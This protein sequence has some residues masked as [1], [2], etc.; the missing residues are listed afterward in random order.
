MSTR[1]SH[2]T[3]SIYAFGDPA[4]PGRCRLRVYRLGFDRPAVVI[5]TELPG[6]GSV[7]NAVEEIATNVSR[8]HGIDPDAMLFVEHLMAGSL[9]PEQFWA[10]AFGGNNSG[11]LCRPSW[12]VITRGS[13]EHLTG[14]SLREGGAP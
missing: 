13:V 3:D 12:R 11:R 8:G 14:A 10:V 4:N 9:G 5:A 6:A 1:T 7:S 2:A